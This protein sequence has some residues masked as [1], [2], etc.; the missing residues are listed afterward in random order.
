MVEM[1][2]PEPRMGP[3]GE[4]LPFT[5]SEVDRMIPML[6]EHFA[7]R[8]VALC[9][10]VRDDHG[11]ALDVQVIGWG[12]QM[13]DDDE[14]IEVVCY[15]NDNGNPVHG[16]FKSAERAVRVLSAGQDVRMAWAD[17]ELAT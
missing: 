11:H 6:A 5:E 4:V 12:L 13:G 14:R 10:V 9:G 15:R 8:R 1:D 17:P 3:S 16:S 7:P 2:W